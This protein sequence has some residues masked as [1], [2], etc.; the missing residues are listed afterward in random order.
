MQS[1]A[2][3]RCCRQWVRPRWG[4]SVPCRR[5]GRA[6]RT[7]PRAEAGLRFSAAPLLPKSSKRAGRPAKPPTRIVLMLHERWRPRIWHVARRVAGRRLFSRRG[8]LLV[9][10][11]RSRPAR[12][13]EREIPMPAPM[14]EFLL[15]QVRGGS[16]GLVAV[17]LSDRSNEAVSAARRR[18]PA[19]NKTVR[20]PARDLGVRCE[21]PRRQ[22][23]QAVELLRAG[24]R[25][26]PRRCDAA[27]SQTE[28][29]C[30]PKTPSDRTGRRDTAEHTRGR[31]Q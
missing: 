14:A 18:R 19:A 9:P 17:R 31:L 21:A 26:R 22:A 1:S 4:A 25:R 5:P 10:M 29:R 8:A 15:G 2:W 28:C 3:S 13:D 11:L 24:L 7:A 6:W 12:L 16:P 30:T 23:S 20:E 27:L